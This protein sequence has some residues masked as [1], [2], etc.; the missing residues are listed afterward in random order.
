MSPNA[1]P[2]TGAVIMF[3][4]RGLTSPHARP[5]KASAG[6]VCSGSSTCKNKG[7]TPDAMLSLSFN[8]KLLYLSGVPSKLADLSGTSTSSKQHSTT[9]NNSSPL[10]VDTET[11]KVLRRLH[12]QEVQA[13][14][15]AVARTQLHN[16]ELKLVCMRS[17]RRLGQLPFQSNGAR[18]QRLRL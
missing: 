3:V 11:R 16:V 7:V 5:C 2:R 12:L 10:S 9:L 8:W 14:R 4:S 15:P 6:M 13:Q 18:P 1:R 17:T